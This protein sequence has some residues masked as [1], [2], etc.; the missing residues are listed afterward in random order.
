MATNG[1]VA[2]VT[3]ASRGIGKV[4]A[5]ALARAGFKVVI[6]A[7]TRSAAE[8]RRVAGNLEATAELIA[9]VGGEALTVRLDVTDRA[10]LAEA[11]EAAMSTWGRIDVLVNN[12]YY[13]S[14]ESERSLLDLSVEHL[15]KQLAGN[16]LAP[17]A[18]AKLVLPQMLDRGSG[19]VVNMVS[20]TG[21]HE[22]NARPGRRGT[23][24]GYATSKV[25]LIEVA[26]VLAAQ[27]GDRGI[28]AFSIQPGGV[29]T[30][31]VRTNIEQGLMDA[32]P[33]D[34]H[35][36]PAEHSALAVVWLATAPEA[37]ALNG[38]LIHAPTFVYERG[39]VPV[40]G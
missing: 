7:R 31:L 11:V 4:T 35:W 19:T 32:D 24:L 26:G 28:R 22:P 6:G 38:A 1:T 15:E 16:L 39:L 3:G 25:G 2:F 8:Q 17:M 29:L 37:A 18:L 9:E 23:N 10:S 33:N 5:I 14:A 27:F 36:T 13:A 12:A 20:G 40:S 34:G 30:E 21:I